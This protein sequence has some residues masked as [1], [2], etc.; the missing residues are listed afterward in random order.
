VKPQPADLAW[1]QGQV[2]TANGPLVVKWAQDTSKFHLQI[3]SPANT[4]GEVWVPLASATT[5]ISAPLTHGATFVRRAGNYDIYQVGA[6]TFEFASGPVTF[7]S[8]AAVVTYFSSDPDVTAG[9]VA[10]LLAASVARNAN[11]RNN[12]LDAFVNQVNAQTGKALTPEEA[13]VLITLSAAL[14]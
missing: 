2:P 10:K 13:Q 4:G 11:A 5:S 14:R 9:L 6:G 12:Q 1:T 8:L 7:A 3:T